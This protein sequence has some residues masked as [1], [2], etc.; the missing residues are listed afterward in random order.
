MAFQ[1]VYSLVD[2]RF[3]EGV[4]RIK[5]C[6]FQNCSGLMAVA[7]PASLVVIDQLAFAYC[8]NLRRLTFA[9]DSKLRCIGNGAFRRCPLERVFLPASVTE[10][11]PS[12][13]FGSA[14][15]SVTFGGQQF[16]S[17]DGDFLCSLDSRTILNYLSSDITIEIP[18]HIEVIGKKAFTEFPLRSVIFASGSRLREIGEGAFSHFHDFTEIT[19]PSSVEILGDRCFMNCYQLTT[20]TF[21]EISSLK[22]IGERAFA[23]S[24]LESFTIPAS[25]NEIDGSAF[26][27]CPLNAID[28]AAGNRSFIVRGNTLVRSDGTEIVKSFGPEREIFVA[29]EVEVLHDSCFESLE[30]LT[31]LKIEIGSKL[32]RI[33]RSALSGCESLR[34][35]L[36]P[37]S[38]SEIA[39]F[40]FKKCIGLEECSIHE[41]AIL[42]K[43]GQGAFAGCSCLKSFYVPKNVERMG[44]NCFKQCP[45][46][47]RLKFG[48][49]DTL[50]KLVRDRTLDESL[51]HHG[52]PGISR[53]FR[54]EVGED[55]TDLVFP[56]WIPVADDNS[57]LT[58][59][60][61]F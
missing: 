17:V 49:G 33:G 35:I 15:R 21:E 41:E 36:L 39:D 26:E 57:H 48:S 61:G 20:I 3:E 18:A 7:F 38:L 6:T 29:R 34:L 8:E 19:I 30:S 52:I 44:E 24:G 54:I 60:R 42:T 28:I 11:D 45:S 43:I 56:G 22:R 40:A 31:E 50:K 4:E 46:L 32:R 51:E 5:S 1:R 55:A 53:I 23:Y 10:I 12:A 27:G 13:F 16:F 2:L 9:A 37:P 58:L 25:A 14:W 59:S 47:F